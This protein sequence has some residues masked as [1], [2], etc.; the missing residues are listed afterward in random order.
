MKQDFRFESL[1]RKDIGYSW[2]SNYN[3]HDNG[4]FRQPG[5]C[6]APEAN[7]YQ[8]Y[9]DGMTQ[10]SKSWVVSSNNIQD[11]LVSLVVFLKDNPDYIETVSGRW[12]HDEIPRDR[13]K[14]YEGLRY[15]PDTHY[16]QSLYNN[17][18]MKKSKSE[19]KR[20]DIRWKEIPSFADGSFMAVFR[21]FIE[22]HFSAL[23]RYSKYK[24]IR[25]VMDWPWVDE[26]DLKDWIGFDIGASEN[27][28]VRQ[29]YDTL[30]DMIT[31]YR[32]TSNGLNQL[33]CLMRNMGLHEDSQKAA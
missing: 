24:S 29:A 33:D 26:N 22:S 28:H 23:E 27:K 11:F 3:A 20:Y 21:F 4:Y 9:G 13:V 32:H 18:T 5:R 15:D 10:H 19:K 16:K 8:T 1:T 2:E 17:E 25:R 6:I 12:P 31:G 14:F 7:E 30:D